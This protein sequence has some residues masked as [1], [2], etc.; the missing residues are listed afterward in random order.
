M[1]LLMVPAGAMALVATWFSMSGAALRMFG[2]SERPLHLALGLVVA[3][4]L[5]CAW[6]LLALERGCRPV[7]LL[8]WATALHT[9]MIGLHQVPGASGRNGTALLLEGI[10]LLLASAL[11]PPSS[12]ADRLAR[13]RRARQQAIV[14]LE[15]GEGILVWVRD[16]FKRFALGQSPGAD[17]LGRLCTLADRLGRGHGWDDVTERD[18]VPEALRQTVRSELTA[19][20]VAADQALRSAASIVERRAL[21]GGA[22]CRDLALRIE[23]LPPSERE[24]LAAVCE[25]LL[26]QSAAIGCVPLSDRQ[27]KVNG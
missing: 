7:A 14:Q 15:M 13:W 25:A 20:R 4:A 3:T 6:L 1:R 16:V 21:E 17:R 8:V 24:R 22:R 26:L 18:V 11:A 5:H 27:R 2:D 12:L 23:S 10:P 9:C 19:L